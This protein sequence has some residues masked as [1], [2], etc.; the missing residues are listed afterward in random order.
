[1]KKKRVRINNPT[2]HRGIIFWMARD[3][4][5]PHKHP[6]FKLSE[7]DNSTNICYRSSTNPPNLPK[8]ICAN[9]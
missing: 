2:N 1:M 5:H 6:N 7:L 4:P 3:T 8:F 9:N